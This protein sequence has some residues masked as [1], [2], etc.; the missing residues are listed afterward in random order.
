[1][2]SVTGDVGDKNLGVEEVDDPNGF[3][4]G[5]Q[6]IRDQ[7]TP[8]SDGYKQPQCYLSRNH[9]DAKDDDAD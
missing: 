3:R 1:M 2:V 5:T 8:S 6:K 9:H 7:R 4:I